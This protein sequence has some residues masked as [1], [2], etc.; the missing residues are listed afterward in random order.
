M[1]KAAVD[2]LGLRMRLLAA[3]CEKRRCEAALDR[4]WTPATSAALDRAI[5][6]VEQAETAL[7]TPPRRPS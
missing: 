7:R 6:A 3:R 1:L 2:T 5:L 4:A